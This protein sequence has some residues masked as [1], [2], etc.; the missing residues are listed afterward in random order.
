[1]RR[2]VGRISWG[3]FKHDKSVGTSCLVNVNDGSDLVPVTLWDA[4]KISLLEFAKQTNEKIGRARVGKDKD[5]KKATASANFVPSFILQPIGFILTYLSTNCGF[6][7]K[8]L[9]MRSDA[10]GHVVVTNI[11]PFGLT[12]AF[13]PLCPPMHAIGF[14]C[15]G[16]VVKKP[17]VDPKTGEIVIADMMNV[18]MTGDHRFGDA[19]I[20]TKMIKC[21]VGYLEDPENFKSEDYADNPH[22]SEKKEA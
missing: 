14:F 19:A 8:P 3:F 15:V 12:Q 2:N 20:F 18:T 4:H 1:M 9:G 7:F 11:G 22:W 10:F 16:S 5:H 21:F 6:S 13:A 17:I